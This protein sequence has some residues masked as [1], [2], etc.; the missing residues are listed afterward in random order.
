MK[1]AEISFEIG[2]LMGFRLLFLLFQ[3]C[4]AV[5][6]FSFC[7]AAVILPGRLSRSRSVLP[8]HA[9]T[10]TS[11][12]FGRKH[13]GN[14]DNAAPSKPFK[15]SS[16]QIHSHYKAIQSDDSSRATSIALPPTG[17]AKK[18]GHEHTFSPLISFHK[19]RH[20]R[21]KFRNNVPRPT[22]RALPPTSSQKGPAAVSPIQSPLPSVAGGRLPGPAPS[23]TIQPNHYYMPIP[24]PTTSPMGSYKKK[25]SMPPSQVMMLPPPPPNGDCTIACTEPLTYTPPGTPCG[26]V[27]PI[28]VKI[29]L[30]VAVYT[31][32]PLVS[33]LAEEIAD[34]ISLNQSQVRIMGA[35]AAS[36]QLEKTTVLINLVPRGSKFNHNTAFFIYQKFWRRKISINASLFGRYQVLNVKYPG[37][38]PSPPLAPSGTSSINDGLNTSNTNA[39]NAIKPLGVDVPRRKKEGLGRNMIAVITISSFTALVMCVGLA[40]LCLLRCRASTHQPAQI[41]ENLIASTRKPPGTAGLLIIG[42][43]PGSS[44]M[45]L[46]TD[47]MTYIGAAKNFTLKDMEK[48]T[49]N[50]DT[51]RILGEGGFGIVYS[52]S[53]DDG[54]EVA[55][56]VLKRH[57]QHGIREFLAEVEMLSRLHHRNLVK[58]IGICTED[59]IRCLVYELVPNGSVESHLHGI[60]KL[61]SP[62]DWDAR[63]KI[64]LGAARGLAYLHEDSNPRV[65]HRDFKASNILL[66]YDFTPKV[67]DF[68]LARTALEEG[69]KHI[70]TH[71]MGTFGYLAPEYAMTGHLLVKSDVY[72]YGVV[73]LELLTGRKPVD[74]SLPPGQENLVAWARPLLTSKEGLD[75]ITD[76]AIK[77]DISVDSLARVA[78]IA[79]MCVQPEVSHRPFMGEVVQALKLVCNEFEE[80]NDPVS[81]SYSRDELL[82]YMDSK[83]GGI[84]GEILNAPETSHT[85]PSGKE[86]NVGLSASDLIS[87]S[88]R[89]EGQELV[90]SRWHSSNSEPLRTGK[91]KHLWQKLRSLSRGSFSEHGFSAKL[92]PGFH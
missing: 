59:Q 87:A 28:Q 82:S 61:T 49:D 27:W 22:F 85:F 70:S 74:L 30:D 3:I 5:S 18:W 40:W 56:K 47:P 9:V 71:V 32:F 34:S 37:L 43:E 26:C 88:A 92:W 23:P 77:S 42:S 89:F 78:A 50:F 41:P 45:P 55:V 75:A 44:S 29:T 7:E 76:P 83:F 68:G 25:K 54:R 17:S 33:E 62:L 39:G 58:L 90:S 21:R 2:T 52:G 53:L 69:N 73:L 86:T 64:A 60:D 4:F 91:K 6:S 15:S 19:F 66:E 57:N 51:A 81:R 31:F 16:P 79:S 8:D 10:P 35:D 65:I 1:T 48:A 46:D 84:S 63:M 20:S 72:S 38:P 14:L 11:H 24:A 13:H 12:G 80:T 36:Q 67:S